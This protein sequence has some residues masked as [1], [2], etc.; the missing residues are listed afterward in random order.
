MQTAYNPEA[1]GSYATYQD[2]HA[3]YQDAQRQYQGQQGYQGYDQ[4]AYYDQQQHGHQQASY[5]YVVAGA[6]PVPPAGGQAHNES[7]N[8]RAVNTRSIVNDEDVYGGI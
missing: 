7:A 2:P 4:N 8:K 1:Y 6:P 5:D 3:G